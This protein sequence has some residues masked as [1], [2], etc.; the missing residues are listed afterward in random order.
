[1]TVKI[2]HYWADR[3][4]MPLGKLVKLADV[5]LHFDRDDEVLCGLKLKGFVVWERVSGTRVVTFPATE[6]A[7][8]SEQRNGEPL[9]RPITDPNPGSSSFIVRS[10]DALNRVSNLILDA[11]ARDVRARWEQEHPDPADPTAPATVIPFM[12]KERG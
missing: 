5:E 12:A 7:R 3:Y 6:A 1:M 2:S 10:G 11:Y 8:T 4:D 9:L